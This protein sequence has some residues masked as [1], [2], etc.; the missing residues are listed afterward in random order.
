MQ[1]TM[2]DGGSRVKH[3]SGA[4]REDQNGKG[5]WSYIPYDALQRV[6]IWY[7]L[8]A[9]KYA[10]RNWEKGLS[11]TECA[12]AAARHLWKFMWGWKDEDHLAAV[13]WNV[14]SIMFYEKHVP[15]MCDLPRYQTEGGPEDASVLHNPDATA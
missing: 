4:L 12:N 7:E 3:D 13:V 5:A 15:E 2:Q 8:G 10:P 11:V 9:K 6:A 14:F 1:T